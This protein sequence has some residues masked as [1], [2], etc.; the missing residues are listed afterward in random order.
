MC[1]DHDSAYMV[2]TIFP[3]HT[4]YEIDKK[5]KNGNVYYWHYHPDRYSHR[6][7]WFY[8]NPPR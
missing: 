8:G 4:N 3:E 1:D 6:H 7:I 2:A 5:Q